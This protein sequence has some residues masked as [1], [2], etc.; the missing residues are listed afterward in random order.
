MS[1]VCADCITERWLAGYVRE[2]AREHECDFCENTSDDPIAV[3]LEDIM[4]H[5][6]ERIEMIYEDP[7]NSVMYETAEAG[8]QLATMDTYEVL[9][10]VG[11]TVEN[12]DLRWELAQELGHGEWVHR[13]PYSLPEEDALQLSW[14]SFAN[15]VKHRVRY[16]MFPKSKRDDYSVREGLEPEEVLDGLGDAI[17]RNGMVSSLK[18]GTR[19]YRVRL[20]TPGD[21]P[22]NTIAALG[23]PPVGSARFSN[24][25]S[26]AGMSM[27]YGALSEK[28]ALEETYVR[29]DGS[30]AEAT[31]AVFE[32]TQDV[33]V[34]DLT[35]LPEYPSVFGSD[36]ANLDRPTV[37]FIHSF[38]ND[39]VQPVEKDGREHV[40]YVPSQ[41]VTEY[42]RH[43]L[44]E[45]LGRQIGGILY[46]SARAEGEV[47]CVLFVA[48]EDITGMLPE[49]APF[50]LLTKLTRTINVDTEPEETD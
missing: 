29:Y 28:V 6:R 46:E 1:R 26:P 24:R 10:D 50:K 31:I 38:A 25:M 2:N 36:E 5:I 14:E 22:A 11:L 9:E 40:D 7:A 34:V 39:F 18:T 49:P 32:M 15:T 20:H 16:L 23:P 43:R 8:Y 19:V 44:G 3:D 37:H 33:E 13:N 30:P 21:T 35:V 48:H 47:A 4:G 17:V 41:V 42:I 45:K 27:F 12:D